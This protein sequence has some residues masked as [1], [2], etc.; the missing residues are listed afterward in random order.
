MSAVSK[1]PGYVT[2]TNQISAYL[3]SYNQ[4]NSLLIS[5]AVGFA[6]GK[7]AE[8]TATYIFQSILQDLFG[9]LVSYL[10]CPVFLPQY[11]NWEAK[12]LGLLIGSVSSGAI[13]Y[14]LYKKVIIP[15]IAANTPYLGQIKKEEEQSPLKTSE[16]LVIFLVNQVVSLSVAIVVNEARSYNSCTS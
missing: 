3:F 16:V 2:I 1:V 8:K 6:M 7:L 14:L 13:P 12:S 15:K 9:S 4:I 11:S 10:I 5:S